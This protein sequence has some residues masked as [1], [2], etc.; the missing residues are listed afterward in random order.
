V[1]IPPEHAPVVQLLPAQH[2]LPIVPHAR[3]LPVEQICP[4][5]QFVLL[6]THVLLPRQQP[7]CAA[8]QM[9]PLQHTAPAAPHGLHAPPE[10]TSPPVQ[11]PPVPTQMGP[12]LC[13]VS[14]HA[15]DALH[16]SPAQH[17]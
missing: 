11:N 3:Q 15:P 9:P 8:P 10:Q 2:G 17:G 13:A 14:Q 16:V 5:W 1:H 4:A 7:S 6:S 12:P